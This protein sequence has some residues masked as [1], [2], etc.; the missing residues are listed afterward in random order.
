MMNAH[1]LSIGNE[2]LI[3][4]TVNTNAAWIGRF[5]TEQGFRVDEVRTIS[6]DRDSIRHAIRSAMDRASLVITTGGLG[7]THDDITLQVVAELF[8]KKL[9]LSER[10]LDQLESQFARRNLELTADNR[11]LARVPEGCEVLDNSQGTAPGIWLQ[12]DQSA[13]ALLPGVPYEMRAMMESSVSE[14]IRD[15][16][17]KLQ[18]QATHYLKTA[19]VTESTLSNRLVGDLDD[20]IRDG[21]GIAYL[22]SVSGVTIRISRSGQSRDE[23]EERLAPVVE[24]IR[25]KAG[26]AVYG[27]GRDVTLGEVVGR[28]LH[29]RQLTIATAESCTGGRIA[30]TLT[31][32]PGSGDYFAGGIVTYA[33]EAKVKQLNIPWAVLKQHGAVSMEVALQMAR[34]VSEAFGADVGIS[35]TGIAG[36]GGGTSAKPVGTVWMGFWI[37]GRH[38]ALKARFTNDR[39]VNKTRTVMVSLD[40]VRRQ[41]LGLDSYPYDF[42]PQ[43]L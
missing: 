35:A 39:E 20:Y 13:L 21:N 8:N 26:D 25:R 24:H 30:D 19:G 22:P 32:T 2:L 3:G 27:E 23:A 37:E 5:L 4:D 16:F 14:K 40:T 34:E 7:P 9:V 43:T 1:I 31:N 6:D 12:T 36:P 18:V 38:F 41:L 15:G 42:K 10:V 29:D 17:S 28:L 11:N 33:Y